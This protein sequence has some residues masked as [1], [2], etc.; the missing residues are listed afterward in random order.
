MHTSQSGAFYT[1]MCITLHT[2]ITLT[3]H[4][5]SFLEL[6]LPCRDTFESSDWASEPSASTL[7]G[8]SERFSNTHCTHKI[9]LSSSIADDKKIA[10]KTNLYK[11]N[12]NILTHVSEL[13]TLIDNWM[14]GL[15][16][17]LS[18]LHVVEASGIRVRRVSINRACNFNIR[19]GST[20]FLQWFTRIGDL[21]GSC[22]SKTYKCNACL[23]VPVK[24]DCCYVCEI[25]GMSALHISDGL[26]DAKVGWWSFSVL[27][28]R[29]LRFCDGIL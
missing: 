16:V 24:R 29:W 18:H 11:Q 28:L 4:T 26:V 8:L 7:P 25:W 20:A 2:L 15:S 21:T 27:K 9:K 17:C 12:L 3:W 5:I 13:M 22:K 23:Y 19:R 1:R 10:P 14:P 6:L